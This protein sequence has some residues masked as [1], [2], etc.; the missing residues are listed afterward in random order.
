MSIEIISTDIPGPY[1]ADA[2]D[3]VR[4]VAGVTVDGTGTQGIAARTQAD[5]DIR[6]EVHGTVI[7][8]Y[9]GV[10][11]A[12]TAESALASTL[13][14]SD[15]GRVTGLAPI[16]TGVGKGNQV[17]NHG[18]I[19]GQFG[20]VADG[21]D[22]MIVNHGTIKATQTAFLVDTGSATVFNYG[23][24]EEGGYF[25]QS[26]GSRLVNEG[27]IAGQGGGLLAVGCVDFSLLNQGDI[28]V[29]HADGRA[30]DLSQVSGFEVVNEG[31]VSSAHTGV[32][33]SEA[34]GVFDNSGTISGFKFGIRLSSRAEDDIVISN[35]GEVRSDEHAIWAYRTGM[36]LDNSGLIT[37]D[38]SLDA[39]SDGS[40]Y[41]DQIG[42]SGVIAGD[43]D[44][45]SGQDRFTAR[46]TGHV[47][48]V[49]HGGDG[50]DTIT[51]AGA[52]D[53]LLGDAGN[54]SLC[55][56]IGNDTVWGGVGSD[57]VS[58]A[59]GQDGAWGGAGNDRVW[60]GAGN[61]RVAGGDGDDILSGA[62]GDDIIFAGAGMDTVYGAD[63]NDH[64][65]LGQGA[66]LAYG[67]SGADVFVFYR[68]GSS[69]VI[70]DFE[71]GVDLIDL[72][73]LSLSG[74]ADIADGISGDETRTELTV[75]AS[76]ITLHGFD[77]AHLDAGDFLF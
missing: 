16:S 9:F 1:W 25:G 38:I 52:D 14:I 19:D 34:D 39:G 54:D 22:Q 45:G 31:T 67:G 37:G 29:R 3:T 32:H 55:G 11:L 72:R 60:G 21:P 30:I 35:S 23:V 66:N 2:G 47:T 24:I 46:Q 18:L 62:A 4:V 73:D 64:I 51:G 27:T 58:G 28:S 8:A 56:Q 53:H 33:I 5:T 40:A 36:V 7:G 43:V 68:Q 12:G 17:I 71:D 70:E 65:H 48:G 6:V 74:F 44:L 59:N 76:A 13:Y 63:G 57:V 42:N 49:V 61:D 15:T 41:G 10:S 26:T 75:G 20:V 69:A 77:V 50:D